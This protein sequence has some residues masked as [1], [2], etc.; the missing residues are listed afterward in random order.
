MSSK[1]LWLLRAI[2]AFSLLIPLTAPP[3]AL[4]T[5]GPQ[6]TVET[7]NPKLG[8]HTRLTDEVEEWKI[9]R[10]LAMVREMGAPWIV[11]YFPWAYSEPAEGTYDWTHADIVVDHARRQGL[12][13]I[14]RLG[15]VPQ[16]A[17][18]EN[19]AFSY[20]A[21]ER[22]PAFAS[23]VS[24]FVEHF[25]GRIDHII[26]WN[27]PNLSYEWGFQ[28]VDPAQ[29][30]DLLCQAYRAA[31]SVAPDIVVLGGAL[32][33]TLA[34]PG[35]PD[36]LDDLLYLQG[37]YDAG[38]AS[39]FDGLAAHAYGWRFPADTPPA[40]DV[41]NFRRVELLRAIMVANGDEDKPIYITEGGWN[42]HPRW[43]KGVSP[44]NRILYT[45]QAAELARTWPWCEMIAFWAFRYP[46]PAQSY[47]D[48]FTFVNVDFSP[49]PI[50]LALQQYAHGQEV[51]LLGG[52]LP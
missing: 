9:K 33:P 40:E 51:T 50:Y 47:Q 49:K 38:A 10:T 1:F 6:Q 39:C 26:I 24:A 21:P 29:Y 11:E 20:L 25:R 35:H 43:T 45:I 27:E 46:R 19:S 15:F 2:L 13:V 44:G 16:W 3:K 32:A 42:D 4:V 17:R 41:I 30:T 5:L 37:M 34:P 23:F 22:Y 8:V 14:A 12:T 31:K 18:P 7:V 52:E 36:G 28:P 48:Y